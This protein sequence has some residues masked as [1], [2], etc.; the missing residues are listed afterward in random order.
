LEEDTTYKDTVAMTKDTVGK[1]VL[2]TNTTMAHL[3][4]VKKANTVVPASSS[5]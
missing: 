4:E 1:E 3:F 2:V 5:G